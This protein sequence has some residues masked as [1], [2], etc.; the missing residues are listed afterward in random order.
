MSFRPCA[1]RRKDGL[2]LGQTLGRRL[3]QTLVL[4]DDLALTGGTVGSHPRAPRWKEDL[5]FEPA[6]GPGLGRRCAVT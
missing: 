5:T 2:E 3:A 6:L 4:V 1:S